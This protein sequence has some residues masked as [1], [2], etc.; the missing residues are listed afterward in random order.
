MLLWNLEY[1][2]SR[3][4]KLSRHQHESGRLKEGDK[5]AYVEIMQMGV[6]TLVYMILISCGRMT[7]KSYNETHTE[8]NILYV[9]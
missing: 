5:D 7:E 4:Q 6:S 3:L 9:G 8:A 2:F 1:W